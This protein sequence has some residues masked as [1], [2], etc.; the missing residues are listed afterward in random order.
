MYPHLLHLEPGSNRVAVGLKNISSKAITIPS[1]VVVVD[2]NRPGWSLMISPPNLSRAPLG[3]GGLLG[4]GSTKFGGVGILDW[5]T[6]AIS[7]GPLG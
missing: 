6:A 2:Y 5:R 3:E 7:Q 1:R 4:F